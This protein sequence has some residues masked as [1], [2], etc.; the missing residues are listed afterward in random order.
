VTHDVSSLPHH[1]LSLPLGPASELV[2]EIETDEYPE[3]P[4]ALA[5][6]YDGDI[7]ETATEE[8]TL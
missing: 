5:D 4:Q 6:E 8:G 7:L 2:R 1:W 3:D